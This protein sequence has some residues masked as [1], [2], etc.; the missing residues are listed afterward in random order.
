MPHSQL[1]KKQRKKNLAMMLT[2]LALMGLFYALTIVKM[3]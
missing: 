1:H 3:G 2:L